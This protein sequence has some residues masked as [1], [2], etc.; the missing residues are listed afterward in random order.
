MT[1]DVDRMIPWVKFK[2]ALGIGHAQHAAPNFM[3]YGRGV[4]S[5]EASYLIGLRLQKNSLLRPAGFP[6]RLRGRRGG[7]GRR[8][9]VNPGD[10][11][12]LPW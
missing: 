6:G 2:R 8:A 7:L 5:A 12:S 11:L 10:A 4:W 3:T 1:E 9:G